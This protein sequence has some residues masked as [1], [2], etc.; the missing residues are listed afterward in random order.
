MM[1]SINVVIDD[2]SPDSDH[3]VEDSVGTSFQIDDG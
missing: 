3:N 2:L 1:E